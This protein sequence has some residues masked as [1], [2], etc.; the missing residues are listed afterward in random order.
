MIKVS[1]T[2]S[3]H[4]ILLSYA[5]FFQ[6][7]DA[8]K[9]CTLQTRQEKIKFKRQLIPGFVTSHPP[10]NFIFTHKYEKWL[11]R[12][13]K[14]CLQDKNVS[15]ECRILE[16]YMLKRKD[17]DCLQDKDTSEECRILEE[18]RLKRKDIDCLQDKDTSKECRI[19][20]EY[21][22]KRKDKDCLQEKNASEE[23]WILV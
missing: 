6:D 23:C 15:E 14:D 3:F 10:L 1:K 18:Y 7:K 12:K 8:L 11:R 9:E 17:K 4:N 16:E 13:D 19:L 2:Q 20:E 22:L 21:W 5:I